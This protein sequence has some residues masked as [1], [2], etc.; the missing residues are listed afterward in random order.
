MKTKLFFFCSFLYSGIMMAQNPGTVTGI[1]KDE[2][3]KE[4]I[5]YASISIKDGDQIITGD[6]SDDE[7]KFTIKNIPLKTTEVIVE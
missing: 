5:S 4:A 1:L 7:G 3:S 2:N 6:L